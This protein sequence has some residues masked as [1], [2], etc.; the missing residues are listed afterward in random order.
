M[1]END[2]A[3]DCT[4]DA[5]ERSSTI[6]L[7]KSI[8]TSA[9]VAEMPFTVM[10]RYLVAERRFP[11]VAEGASRSE[12]DGAGGKRRSTPTK[13]ANRSADRAIPECCERRS[14]RIVLSLESLFHSQVEGVP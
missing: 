1:G 5:L 8:S 13:G 11:R 14:R 7:S 4:N 9:P 2:R 6:H 10:R 3:L 12:R